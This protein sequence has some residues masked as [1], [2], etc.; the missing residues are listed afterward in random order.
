VSPVSSSLIHASRWSW[1]SRREVLACWF[2][3]RTAVL[4]LLF[5]AHA[6][7]ARIL[8][9]VVGPVASH[10]STSCCRQVAGAVMGVVQPGEEFDRLGDLLLG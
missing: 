10:S 6:K 3:S 9:R 2:S 1:V 5:L 4:I 8:W 7:K